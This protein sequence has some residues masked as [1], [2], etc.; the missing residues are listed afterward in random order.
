M[1]VSDRVLIYDPDPREFVTRVV[2]SRDPDFGKGEVSRDSP[3]GVAPLGSSEEEERDRRLLGQERR[4][5]RIVLIGSRTTG[6]DGIGQSVRE[7]SW[8]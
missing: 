8:A 6:R 2:V 5:F 3:Y 7:P 1:K 4:P